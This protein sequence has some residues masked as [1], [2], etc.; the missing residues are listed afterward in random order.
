MVDV[1]RSFEPL[2]LPCPRGAYRYD[3]FSPKVG[4]RLTLYKRS[5]FEAWLMLQADPAAKTYCERLRFMAVA[6]QRCVIDFRPASDDH[7]R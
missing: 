4:R 7:A 3:V 1:L 2:T 6:G 5:T